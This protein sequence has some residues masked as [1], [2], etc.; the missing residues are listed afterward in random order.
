MFH[1]LSRDNASGNDVQLYHEV[2]SERDMKHAKINTYA[3]REVIP[4]RC[5]MRDEYTVS[6]NK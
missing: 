4:R 5:C 3:S 1:Q 2:V 6:M